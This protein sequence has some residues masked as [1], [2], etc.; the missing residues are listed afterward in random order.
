LSWL[1]GYE[2]SRPVRVGNAAHA[3][4]QLDVFGEIMDALHQSRRGGIHMRDADWAF[5]R[6]L[7]DHL[8]HVWDQPD[9]GMWEIRGE[10]R[11][12]TYSKVMAWVAFDR[13]IQAVETLGLDGPVEEW[14]VLRQRIHDDVCRSAFDTSIGSFVQSYG[15]N[16]LDASLLL[17]PTVGFLRPDDPRARGTIKAV[18]ER[19]LRDGF[20]LRYNTETG[21]DG[22]PPGEGAFIACSF[23]LADAYVLT[24]RLDDA[25][26]VFERLLTLRTDLGLLSEQYDPSGGRLLGNF[27]QAFSHIALVNTAHN[28]QRAAKPAEQRAAS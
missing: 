8:A 5:Q 14:R 11:H 15:S 16:A 4:L 9:Q 6:A 2:Q 23:W 12:F 28:L 17:I 10:P 27:P 13:G 1:P 18:E 3:Q 26:K 20:L 19:L 24:G 25:Q 7:L 21:V 22:L